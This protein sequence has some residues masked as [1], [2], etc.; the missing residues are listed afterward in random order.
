MQTFNLATKIGFRT[1]NLSMEEYQRL[2]DPERSYFHALA[3]E[4]NKSWIESQ[5]QEHKAGWLMVVDGR[6]IAYGKSLD[7][8]PDEI[9][10][11]RICKERGEFPFIFINALLLAIEESATAWHQTVY[12]DD[13]YATIGIR[14]LSSD[15]AKAINLVADFDSGAWGTFAELDRLVSAGIIETT[16]FDV[17]HIATHLNRGYSYILKH[18]PVQINGAA[19]HP[20]ESLETVICVHDWCASPFVQI[21][22]S[23]QALVGRHLP[24]KLGLCLTLDFAARCTEVKVRPCRKNT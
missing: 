18:L 20:H 1:R 11:R 15:R 5:L 14:L 4:E 13:Y 8:Y 23:R 12:P 2:S 10:V 3:R 17:P 21:N 9:E 19:S 22:P 7:D 24:A 6:V 16:L